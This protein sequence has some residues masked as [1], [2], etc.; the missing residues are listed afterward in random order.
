M[1]EE[2]KMQV[3]AGIGMALGTIVRL[4]INLGILWVMLW[5]LAQFGWLPF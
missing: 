1:R 2:T 5:V 3:A 4:A